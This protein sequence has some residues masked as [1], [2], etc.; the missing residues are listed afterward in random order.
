M[1]YSMKNFL[2]Y[3]ICLSTFCFVGC[4]E[5]SKSAYSPNNHLEVLKSYY[6]VLSNR[7]LNN[8]EK[9]KKFSPIILSLKKI[10][11]AEKDYI[12]YKKINDNDGLLSKVTEF[13]QYPTEDKLRNII[14]QI[15]NEDNC[16]LF[17]ELYNDLYQYLNKKNKYL[18]A[19]DETITEYSTETG[20]KNGV[21]KQ[22]NLS[23]ENIE[24]LITEIKQGDTNDKTTFSVAELLNKY[25]N[26]NQY[27]L[28]EHTKYTVV[29]LDEY[30][31]NVILQHDDTPEIFKGFLG[32]TVL[33]LVCCFTDSGEYYEE[34]NGFQ[35]KA[36]KFLE[37]FDPYDK[38]NNLDKK[39]VALYEI[40]KVSDS[41]IQSLK[42]DE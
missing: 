11:D 36:N 3:S 17:H 42:D 37:D 12:F 35:T 26:N 34:T 20:K 6:D 41:R 32:S 22:F 25:L 19:T 13:I 40:I 10:I 16:I 8:A 24:N 7:P 9:L 4:S 29:T 21:E 38:K 1:N 23:K 31:E 30:P 28:S 2:R 18:K 39:I 5:C 15:P 33:K 14:D 27:V